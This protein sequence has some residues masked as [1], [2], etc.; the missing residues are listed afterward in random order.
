MHLQSIAIVILTL[1]TNACLSLP[2]KETPENKI[3]RCNMSNVANNGGPP[4]SYNDCEGGSQVNR[5]GGATAENLQLPSCL[6]QSAQCQDAFRTAYNQQ[7]EGTWSAQQ[8]IDAI[9]AW[10]TQGW[11]IVST[12]GSGASLF[13]GISMDATFQQS[14]LPS[15]CQGDSMDGKSMEGSTATNTG[16][17]Q[18]QV[19]TCPGG[20]T[21]SNSGPAGASQYNSCSQQA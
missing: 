9:S 15:S 2:I 5:V 4:V 3:K 19:D 6:G 13:Q 16:A 17:E 12:C 10:N 18:V 20:G 7:I 21:Q 1:S 14:G 11:P 8:Q